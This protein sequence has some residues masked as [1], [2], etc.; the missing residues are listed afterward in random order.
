VRGY[1]SDLRQFARWLAGFRDD[2][3]KDPGE[4]DGIATA[5][6]TQKEVADFLAAKSQAEVAPGVRRYSPSTI[7]RYLAAISWEHGRRGYE[8]SRAHPRVRDTLRGIRRDNPVP[9]QRERR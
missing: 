6:R 1:R 7:S 9:V 3:V 5:P 8:L 4:L 2:E